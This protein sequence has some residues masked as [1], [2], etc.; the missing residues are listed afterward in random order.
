M[1]KL[2]SKINKKI[3]MFFIIFL[4][5]CNTIFVSY[6]AAEED[7]PNLI[8]DRNNSYIP[9]NITEGKTS[10][11]V[12]KIKNQGD[13]NA[14][15]NIEVTLKIDD[16][17]ITSNSSS[18]DLSPGSSIFIN[19][20]WMPS[21]AD[22]GLHLLSIEV[23][24]GLNPNPLDVLD[25]PDFKVLE[26][27]TEIEIK[28]VDLPDFFTVNKTTRIYATILNKGKNSSDNINATLYSSIDGKV[29]TVVKED[30]LIRDET[31]DFSFNWTPSKIGSQKISVGIVYDGKTHDFKEISI[32][33]GVYRLQWWNENWH[34]RQFLTVTGTGN[35]SESFDFT[36]FLN[37]IGVFSQ[38]FE[39]NTIR[40]IEYNRYGVII[41][42]IINYKFDEDIDFDPVYNSLGTI[43]WNITGSPKE[44]YYC[45]YFDVAN[46]I[47]VRTE[48]DET[49]N[50]IESGDASIGYYGLV[51]GWW[52]D[53][54]EPVNGSYSRIDESIDI[55]VSTKAKAE[56]VSA[57][58][59]MTENEGHKYTLSLNGDNNKTLWKYE[60]F[61]FDEEGNWTIRIKS[62]DWASYDPVAVEHNFFVGKPDVEIVNI[63]LSTNRPL[64]S[65]QIYKNDIVNI[66][67]NVIAHKATVENVDISLT[68]FDIKNDKVIFVD[69]SNITTLKDEYNSV[70]FNWIAN[71]SGNINLTITLDPDG[72][73]DEQNESN[74]KITMSI[75]VNDWPDL[76]FENII[77]PS[78][79]VK[80]FDKVKININI[81]NK[82]QSNAI[83]YKIG[84]YIEPVTQGY[85]AY[86]TLVDSILVSINKNNSK[87]VSM[88]WDSAKIGEW[89]VGVMV[90]VNDTKMDPFGKNRLLS[91]KNL[92]VN[93]IERNPPMIW[94]VLVEPEYQEQ[95]GSITITAKVNDDS[96][97]DSVSINITNPLG[98][99]YNNNS[100]G[101]T[102]DDE[103]RYYF[104]NTNEI[105]IYS[106]SINAI[107]ITHYKNTAIKHGNFSIYKD[108][109][110][111][112]ILFFEA[113]PRVQL[114]GKSV[115]IS[116]ITTDNIEISS[117]VARITTPSNEVY[118]R[119]MNFITEDKYAYSN[120]YDT[121][122]KY[123]FKIEVEDIANNVVVTIDKSFWITSDLEDRDNDG[124]SDSW[125]ERHGLDPENPN[126]AENDPD[127]DDYSNLEEYKM[128]TNPKKDIFSE[129]AGYRIKEN[130][131]YLAG[132]VV[133]FLIIILLSFF[134]KRRKLI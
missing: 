90:I 20:D 12:V 32:V 127:G 5:L 31:F 87:Q 94:D 72:L 83:D 77:L 118:E 53:L 46:N 23:Y 116:C 29:E 63:T 7:P 84:L 101:R 120:T 13:K 117:I 61:N 11:F 71:V 108:S 100:M 126:D 35:V 62:R 129:N 121:I 30:S 119:K 56:N 97:L 44:K 40:I 115:N 111:P 19:I 8:I 113:Q 134:G 133:L 27:P 16:S 64:T 98:V 78:V 112:I 81:I 132:S 131:F 41:D 88:Y 79:D 114:K 93:P 38:E 47:G 107:D 4:L 125:E 54:L 15:D 25:K 1:L 49:E 106:F 45:I 122:G 2:V 51:E 22:I 39:N 60:N 110:S 70:R 99:T 82:G 123:I 92:K 55:I 36:D 76:E 89:Y 59:F 43:I 42:E 50:I 103:F 95:G 18:D 48:L 66:T 26:R 52:I 68:I 10:E 75:F 3:N 28:S 102:T 67:A 21:Y 128:G 6:G 65:P 80:E 105:G 104:V 74:N 33:V 69:K 124:M 57:F 91:N 109:T 17:I 34:Y 58:I 130:S 37:S 96:G 73:I 9:D 24:Y 14:I 86:S 85:M